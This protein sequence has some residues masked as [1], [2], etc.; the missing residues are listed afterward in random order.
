MGV[1]PVMAVSSHRVKPLPASTNYNN[2]PGL[3][4]PGLPSSH[5]GEPC[6]DARPPGHHPQAI[7][8]A[9]PLPALGGPGRRAGAPDQDRPPRADVSGQYALPDR[10][11]PS[12]K[13]HLP[14]AV[15]SI[16]GLEDDGSPPE[17]AGLPYQLV[18]PAWKVWPI[19]HVNGPGKSASVVS[20]NF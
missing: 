19:P 5:P 11:D 18:L 17:S 16:T 9:V 12:G 15:G 2:G 10:E 1:A 13:P 3:E 20:L 8:P 14:D 4:I 7:R 6:L